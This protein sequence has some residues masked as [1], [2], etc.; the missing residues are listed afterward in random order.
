M[1]LCGFRRDYPQNEYQMFTKF[2]SPHDF[3]IEMQNFKMNLSFPGF[4]IDYNSTW[5]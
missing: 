5:N 2:N 4:Y 3:S 1:G